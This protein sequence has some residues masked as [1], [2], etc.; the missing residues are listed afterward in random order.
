MQSMTLGKDAVTSTNLGSSCMRRLSNR[1]FFVTVSIAAIV[2][3]E[4]SSLGQPSYRRDQAPGFYRLRMGDFEITALYDGAAVFDAHWLQGGDQTTVQS[5]IEEAQRIPH[6]LD[7]TVSAFLV[8]TGKHLILV[9]AGTGGWYGGPSFG[10]LVAN[11]GRAGYTT[12]QIDLVLLTHLH[13]DHVGGLTTAS[14]NRVFQKAKLYVAE[15]D[16][17]FWITRLDRKSVV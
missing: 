5:I 15:A 17:D 7:A 11:L 10:K 3:M 6:F 2:S 8:N 4:G 13:A 9:D 12:G 14:G 16:S 1:V